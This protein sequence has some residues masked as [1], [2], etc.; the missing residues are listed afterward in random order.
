MLL[1]DAANVAVGAALFIRSLFKAFH[2]Y[3]NDSLAPESH[4]VKGT[5][6]VQ[7]LP[8][9]LPSLIDIKQ[10][11]PGHC[12]KS[13]V[14]L[15]LF[16]ALKDV[17]LVSGAFVALSCLLSVIDWMP[18]RATLVLLYWAAQGTFFF[19][20]FVCGHDCGHNSFSNNVLLNDGVGTFMHS[21][22][23]VPYYQWKLSHRNHHKNTG[24]I[25]KDEVFYPV[26]TSQS[27]HIRTL[28]GFAFG[29]GWFIYL[30]M[31]YNPRRCRHFDPFDRMFLGHLV[32]CVCS[33]AGVCTM[34]YF[35]Y[36]FYA[37]YGLVSL[38]IYYLVPLFIG[39]SYIVVVTF[40]HH[41]EMNI[42]WYA[43]DRWDFVKGQLSTVDRHY[44]IVH[45][46]IHNIGTH[47]MHHMFTKIPH[48][49][50]EEAT[51]H[52]RQSFPKLVKACDE[53]IL[54]TF[55]RMFQ[56]YDE[57]SIIPDD[58]KQCQYK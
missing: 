13:N 14:S 31:G 56:K 17:V 5:G 18:L 10:A 21:F 38:A 49:H 6:L 39:S 1:S 30:I 51:R 19:A 15:S 44:G 22:L 27:S 48:Y 4:Q 3:I 43:D 46:I 58:T 45:E 9:D 2:I 53:P 25:D 34:L 37:S 24:N 41:S 52:F 26:R 50:L 7:T 20:V 8:E 42:P 54:P 16:Y 28:P 23:L 57:Q 29:F 47:Q 55:V 12:F 32:G 35:V 36:L 11:L 33:L 40:L